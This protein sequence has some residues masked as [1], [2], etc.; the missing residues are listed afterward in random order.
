[1]SQFIKYATMYS[2]GLLTGYIIGK[3]TII[4]HVNK[5][6]VEEPQTNETE[7]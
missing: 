4:V 1:M 5:K 3:T 6:R 2:V 7:A